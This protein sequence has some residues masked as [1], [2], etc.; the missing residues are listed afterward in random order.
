MRFAALL[1]R[2]DLP[3]PTLN[4]LL[5]LDGFKIEADCLWSSRRVIVELDGGRAH[6][7]RSAF[8]F[9]PL[10]DSAAGVAPAFTAGRAITSNPCNKKPALGEL[11]LGWCLINLAALFLRLRRTARMRLTRFPPR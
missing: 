3:K 10:P 8:E 4:A 11:R 5:D 6:R 1:A 2:T 9:K 7:T